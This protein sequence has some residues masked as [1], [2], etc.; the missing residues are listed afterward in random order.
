MRS[1]VAVPYTDDLSSLRPPSRHAM[2]RDQLH[3]TMRRRVVMFWVFAMSVVVA[4]VAVGQGKGKAK[5]DPKLK[6]RPVTLKTRDG[7]ALRAFYFP[8]D[9]GKEAIPVILVHEWGGQASPY[10]KLV[11]A[12]RDAGCAVLVPDYRGHGGSKQ[13]TDA[14]GQAQT[15]NLATMNRRD[16]ETILSADLEAAK[17]FLKYENDAGNLNLNALVMIGV[18]EG[19]VLASHFTVRDWRWPSVGRKK[20]GQDVKGLVLISPEKQLK[21]IGIDPTLT[22]RNLL[23]LPIMLVAGNSSSE[24]AETHRIAKR[25]EGVKRRVGQGQVS[26][27]EQL[28]VETSLSGPALVNE[29]S[30]VI[31]AV[32]EFVKANVNPGVD[33]NPWVQRD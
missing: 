33:A 27:L 8:S 19:A 17:K 7:V 6:P 15:F 12:L 14:R 29:A 18:R 11:V 5:E 26:G 28:M 32:V 13:Y 21:G 20:Q 3:H 31:P 25:I 23:R 9:Q 16:I 22:D 24:A 1:A 30:E 2:R 4:S 10:Y